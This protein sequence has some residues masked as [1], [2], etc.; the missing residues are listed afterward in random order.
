MFK[1]YANKQTNKTRE[2]VMIK[3]LESLTPTSPRTEAER[4]VSFFVPSM[5]GVALY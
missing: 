4:S 5:T 2:V 1:K 3:I